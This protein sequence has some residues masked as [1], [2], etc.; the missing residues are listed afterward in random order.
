MTRDRF[1]ALER[2]TTLFEPPDPSFG[3]F[4]QRRD[5]RRRNE[6]VAAAAVGLAVFAAMVWAVANGGI[7]RTTRPPET[8]PTIAPSYPGAVGLQKL[9]PLGATPS[10]PRRGELVLSFSYGHTD[11]GDPGRFSLWLYADGRLIWERLGDGIHEGL[12]ATGLIEQRLTPEGVERVLSEVVSTGLFDHDLDLASGQGLFSGEVGVRDGERL[13]RVTWGDG[14]DD[15]EQRTAP[16][17]HQADSL[18]RLDARLLNPTAWLPASAWERREL[19]PFLPSRF[20]VCYNHTNE[21]TSP[22][23]EDVLAVFPPTAA[24]LLRSWDR[25]HENLG[26]PTVWCS[27]VTTDEAHILADILQNSGNPQ[28]DAGPELGYYFGGGPEVP[29]VQASLRFTP[30]LPHEP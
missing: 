30:L 4:L 12:P 11:G 16:T 26:G 3:G 15:G 7:P 24:N 6:R 29:R 27:G 10:S 25:T 21:E 1:D 23:F 5:R 19:G 2:F 28:V 17:R 13:V 22:Q 18:R 9:P 20:A 8:E 14:Y